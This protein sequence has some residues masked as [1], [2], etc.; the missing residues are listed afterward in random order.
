[1][2]TNAPRFSRS[3]LDRRRALVLMAA[4]VLATIAVAQLLVASTTKSARS[5]TKSAA[6]TTAA[7]VE[8]TT[9]GAQ[10]LGE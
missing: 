2:L 9:D 5:A 7:A 4:C 8:A 10:K 1:M 6:K 3:L